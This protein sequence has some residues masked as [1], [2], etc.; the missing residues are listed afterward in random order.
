MRQIRFRD[1]GGS[2]RTGELVDGTVRF[3]DDGY[4][5]AE[6]DV[7]P[8]TVPSKIVCVGTNYRDHLEEVGMAVPDRPIVFLKG[9]N[10]AAGHGDVVTLREE[11]TYEHEA[12]LGVVVGRQCRDVPAAEWESVVAGFTC[13]NEV[14]YRTAQNDEINGN[15]DLFRG[16]AFD[17][18]F[19]MGPV[20]APVE[21]VPADASIELRVNGETRQHSERD[22]M[23]FG[24]PELVEDITRHVTLE[25]GDVICTGTPSGVGP[26]TDG[27]VIEIEIEGVGTLRHGVRSG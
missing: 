11:G 19:P 20:V 23:V 3:G 25:R 16:K 7:L 24:V 17:N 5:V 1:P 10:A 18:S 26:M 4:D 8:P 15:M 12:E 6:V 13:T 21:D 22:R 2:V 9:P 14:S 27:D